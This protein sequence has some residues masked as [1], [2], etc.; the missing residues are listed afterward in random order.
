MQGQVIYLTCFKFEASFS[1]QRGIEVKIQPKEGIEW[2]IDKGHLYGKVLE[3]A[4]SIFKEINC[5]HG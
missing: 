1:H 2:V 3:C 5:H 4:T